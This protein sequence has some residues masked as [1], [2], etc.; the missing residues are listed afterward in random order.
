MDWKCECTFKHNWNV[1]FIFPLE[2]F[3]DVCKLKF[4][5]ILSVFFGFA[6]CLLLLSEYSLIIHPPDNILSKQLDVIDDCLLLGRL[7]LLPLFD[8]VFLNQLLKLS[9]SVRELLTALHKCI[10]FLNEQI[11][12]VLLRN[13]WLWKWDRHNLCLFEH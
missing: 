3:N 10:E 4:D 6:D 9:Q 5:M 11:D 1:F 13:F 7:L 12:W 8:N 2:N